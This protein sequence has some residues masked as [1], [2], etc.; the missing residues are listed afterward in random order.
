MLWRFGM[1]CAGIVAGFFALTL[2]WPLSTMGDPA[3]DIPMLRAR[4]YGAFYIFVPHVL[5]VI[6][7]GILALRQ[8]SLW[9]LAAAFLAAGAF[10]V[11]FTEEAR[12]IRFGNLILPAEASIPHLWLS[13]LASLGLSLAGLFALWRSHARN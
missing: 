1:V 2:I 10:W 12:F 13:K 3:Y 8:S 4:W 9:A 6:V 5:A 7:A 11:I